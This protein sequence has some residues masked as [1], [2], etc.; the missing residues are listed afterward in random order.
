MKKIELID[1]LKGFSIFSIVLLHYLQAL[2]L[3]YPLN[4]LICFGGAGVHLFVLL[5]GLGLYLSYLN[6]PEAYILFIKKRF[7]KVYV[8]YIIVVFITV[9]ISLVLPIYPISTYSICGHIFLY[10]MFDENIIGSY[11]YPLWFIS[12]IFQ[13][14]IFFYTI[15]FL[16][17][18]TKNLSFLIIC[19]G[20]SICWALLLIVLGKGFIRV[21]NGFFLQ[22]LWEFALGMVIASLIHEKY[23]LEFK[24]RSDYILL[25]AVICCTIYGCLAILP[26]GI[27]KLFND[28]PALIG[29][30]LLGIWLY[31]LKINLVNK[32]LLFTGKISYFLY[33]LHLLLL[34]VF[35]IVFSYFPNFIII[36]FA[37]IGSYLASVYY[38]AI[39]N[40]VYHTFKFIAA[41]F[42]YTFKGLLYK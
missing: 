7:S 36:I 20:I 8:P 26:G 19:L 22:Y 42:N 21:W 28:A 27:G 24:I 2:N 1:F 35:S 23:N 30:S 12:M 41:I 3:P 40:P 4:K 15:I 14:Y 32:F 9:V 31:L 13:F 6:K 38:Q 18:H 10:K 5:S 37:L 33:L 34:S 39:L 16:K 25:I 29:F 11:G 17:K